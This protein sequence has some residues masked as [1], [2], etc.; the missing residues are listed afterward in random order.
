MRDDMTG[1]RV[2]LIGGG[3]DLNGRGLNERISAVECE[4]DAVARI[5]HHFG[6]VA[7]VG[8]R[9]DICFVGQREWANWYFHSCSRRAPGLIVAFRDGCACEPGYRAR[10]AQELGMGE[11]VSSGLA[12]VHWLLARGAQVDIIGFNAPGGVVDMTGRKLYADGSVDE[13]P[14]FD[15]TAEILWI[16]EQPGVTLL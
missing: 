13:N 16:K 11:M 10:V 5:N 9:M 4:W 12:A 1:K 14:R 2:L 15:W 3:A 6:E 7:D 8:K